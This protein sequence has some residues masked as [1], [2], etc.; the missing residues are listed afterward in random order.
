MCQQSRIISVLMF[1]LR[2]YKYNTPKLLLA[3]NVEVTLRNIMVAIT[4]LGLAMAMFASRLQQ[5]N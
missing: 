5:G 2:N 3:I 4:K 1:Y